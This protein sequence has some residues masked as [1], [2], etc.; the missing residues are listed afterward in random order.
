M[1]KHQSLIDSLT[2]DLEPSQRTIMSA[3]G[4][5]ALWLLIYLPLLIAVMWWLAP[6]R[7]TV[8][9]QLLTT[10][11]FAFETVLGLLSCLLLTYCA[12]KSSIPGGLARGIQWLTL[13][14]TVSWIGHISLGFYFPTL[15][16]SMAGKRDQC[17][18]EAF[19]YSVPGSIALNIL[20]L[21][22]Y[23]ITPLVSGL[24]AGAAAG[25][26]TA[27]MMQLACMYDAYHGL[28][29]HILPAVVVAIVSAVSVYVIALI[30]RR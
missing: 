24:F 25:L 23:A 8:V 20:V 12:I 28:S 21:R 15:E 13:A 6:F 14:V 5:T 2:R 22:R 30:R 7:E 1:S 3:N 29:H 26:L 17:Y 19:Y 18:F 16:P 10:P 11:R 27:F 9:S 4:A